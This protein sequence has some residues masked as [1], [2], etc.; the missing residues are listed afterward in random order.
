MHR[1][2]HRVTHRVTRVCCTEQDGVLKMLALETLVDITDS[3]V[4]WQRECSAPTAEKQESGG[5]APAGEDAAAEAKEGDDEGKEG[6][7]LVAKESGGVDFEAM[8]HR[9]HDVHEGV[10]KFNMK[11]KRGTAAACA[12]GWVG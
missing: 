8:F 11:P 10:I 7:A 5:L 4:Q 3:M 1:V 6:G 9:K 2:M 12:E